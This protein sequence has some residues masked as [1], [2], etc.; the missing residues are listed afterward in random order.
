MIRAE[1]I[2]L[3]FG[4]HQVLAGVEIS[5][6]TGEILGLVGPNGSGKTTLLRLL[7]GAWRPDTGHVL[8]DGR[9]IARM[10]RREIARRIA[11]VPQERP[12]DIGQSVADVVL[13]G[14]LPRRARFAGMRARD[15]AAVQDALERVGLPHLSHRRVGALSGGEMQRVLI[16]RALAQEAD[17]LLL[18]EPT[19]HLDLHHQFDVLG[20]VRSLGVTTVLVLHDLNLA[21]RYCDRVAVLDKGRL[22]AEG[23][24]AEVLSKAL[25]ETVYQVCATPLSAPGG[26]FHLF[27]DDMNG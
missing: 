6:G 16:A 26:A 19:N 15:Y 23:A 14:R 21:A 25:I 4:R 9:C 12:A 2:G 27:F 18:D 11:V 17:H 7:Y 13:L 20:L 1:G 3:S 24:A 10:R 8:L 22:V 5:V